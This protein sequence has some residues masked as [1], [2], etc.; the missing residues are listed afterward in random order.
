[1][2]D[3]NYIFMS[4]YDLEYWQTAKQAKELVEKHYEMLLSGCRSQTETKL[5]EL[6]KRYDTKT[7]RKKFHRYIALSYR[8]SMHDKLT[9]LKSVIKVILLGN[10]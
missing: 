6:L 8:V 4:C 3:F 5:I 2:N 10:D 1:M 7:A 9:L